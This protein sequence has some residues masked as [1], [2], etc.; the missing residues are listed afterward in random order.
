MANKEIQARVKHKR[1]T[2]SNWTQNN[3]VL[4]NG[5]IILV[6]TA[7]GELRAKVGDGVKTY[8]QLPFSDEALR[9]LINNNK[10]TVDSA[11][12][13]DSTNPVQN[14][15]VTTEINGIKTL[16]GDTSVASQ[17]TAA[18]QAMLPKV[19]TITLGADWEGA[20]SPYYQDVELSCAAGTSIV[21][22]QPTPDQ[23]ASWQDDGL[24]F[25]TLSGDGTVR[26][27]VAGG[28]PSSSITV[29]VKVQEV[30][31]V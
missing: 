17:I 9:S 23:L 1:D 19:T 5:E 14:K 27:Y 11:L 24:A 29:Q 12:S 13:T 31:E 21:D 22:L 30:V 4:L 3:P 10:V 26:I 15:I 20:A 16:I 18:I 6:D 25:T 8:T 7:E 28:L 2:S